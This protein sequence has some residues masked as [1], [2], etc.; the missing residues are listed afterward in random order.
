MNIN[1]SINK[2]ISDMADT[3]HNDFVMQQIVALLA[4]K[5]YKSTVV[6]PQYKIK[7]KDYVFIFII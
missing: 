7:I 1:T 5:I 6:K 2:I 4:S 3:I